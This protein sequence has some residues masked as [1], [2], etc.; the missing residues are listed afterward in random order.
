[1]YVLLLRY[2]LSYLCRTSSLKVLNPGLDS[3][4]RWNGTIAMNTKL[5]SKFTLSYHETV[6][7]FV[8]CFHSK[9]TLWLVHSSIAPKM[10]WSKL[11]GGSSDILPTQT[12]R[13]KIPL[14]NRPIHW[15]TL[16][17]YVR[18]YIHTRTCVYWNS[19]IVKQKGK[20]VSVLN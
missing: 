7:V 1:V 3:M 4:G 13:K 10:L 11:L 12:N 14:K 19:Y 18:I 15:R 16:Y 2:H 8:K 20:V 5:S 17:V 6:T 9:S